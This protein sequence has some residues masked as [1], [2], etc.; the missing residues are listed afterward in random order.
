MQQ[1]VAH[2]MDS[3]F[4]GLD[5]THI[6]LYRNIFFCLVIIAF[7]IPFHIHHADRYR[8]NTLQCLHECIIKLYTS[9]KLRHLQF[10]DRFS[11]CLADIKYC[12][13]TKSWDNHFHNL[14]FW[15]S[16]FTNDWFLCIRVNLFNLLFFS[17]WCRCNNLDSFFPT[18]YM[19]V[20]F[21]LPCLIPC[22]QCCFWFLHGDQQRIIKTVIV[23][24]GH[25][26]QI[27]G[28]SLRS[29]DFF[30]SLLQTFRYFF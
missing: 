10:C 15:L 25:G 27:F 6:F 28:I 23:E 9:G 13:Y 14:C 21:L 22:H 29:K 1:Y 16:I 20:K 12:R 8:R 24:L 11:F 18:F 7:C 30:Y 19:T 3:C 4:H 5:I 26:I 2:L 17:Y